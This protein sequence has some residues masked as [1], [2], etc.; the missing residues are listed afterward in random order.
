MAWHWHRVVPLL[1]KAGYGAIAVDLP[2]DDESAGLDDYAEIVVQ[3]IDQRSNVVLV[4]QSLG[5]SLPRYAM[6]T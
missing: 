4:A 5:P 3:A 1:E 2:R 6:Q